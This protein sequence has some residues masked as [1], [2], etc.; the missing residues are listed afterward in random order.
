MFYKKSVLKK[1]VKFTGK[2]LCHSLFFDKVAGLNFKKKL[3][4]W[5]FPV[6][7]AKFLRTLFLLN[8]SED[9]FYFLQNISGRLPLLSE[10]F[11]TF[12]R[13]LTQQIVTTIKTI[14]VELYGIKGTPNKRFLFYLN[15]RKSLASLRFNAEKGDVLLIL[16]L[17]THKVV[18]TE[19]LT[20]SSQVPNVKALCF[21]F[22]QN[23]SKRAE[24][25]EGCIS[26]Q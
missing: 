2:H 3:W 8:T 18:S 25:A 19:I 22:S 6:N 15:N 5:C 17:R 10:S 9:C 12:K 26:R 21:T 23:L 4:H 7:F 13:L 24:L 14:T 20:S 1:C 16:V 11:Q